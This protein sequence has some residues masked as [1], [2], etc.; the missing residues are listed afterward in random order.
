MML[1]KQGNEKSMLKNIYKISV[2]ILL[3]CGCS[4][5]KDNDQS[6]SLQYTNDLVVSNPKDYTLVRS[7]SEEND[8]QYIC[9]KYF[10]KN[11]EINEE[12][13]F[14]KYCKN[15][16][17]E[18]KIISDFDNKPLDTVLVL[19]Y[20]TQVDTSFHYFYDVQRYPPTKPFGTDNYFYSISKIRDNLYAFYKENSIDSTFS[21]LRF[22]NNEFTLIKLIKLSDNVFYEFL[23][24]KFKRSQEIRE[25][26]MEEYFDNI[27]RIVQIY[28]HESNLFK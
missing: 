19:N 2:S 12:C 14:F 9:E 13:S 21:E 5:S 23:N 6:F 20:F 26:F 3:I 16:I 4:N 28:K 27:T 11:Q 7:I 25:S 1:R 22:Y 17:Y 24:D 10:N 18:V 15:A 8:L